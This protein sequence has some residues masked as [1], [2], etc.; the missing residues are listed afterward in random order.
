[1]TN[2]KTTLGGAVSAFGTSLA[3][4]GVLGQF[5]EPPSEARKILWYVALAGFILSGAGKFF[6]GLWAEDRV[7]PDRA[8]S[9]QGTPPVK[10]P[11]NLMLWLIVGF[12]AGALLFTVTGCQT[13]PQ[14]A[15]YTAV[16]GTALTVETALAGYNQFA[17]AG[18]TTIAQNVQVKLAFDRYQAAMRV[19][20]DAGAVYAAT[21]NTSTPAAAALE[22]AALNAAQSITDFLN[23]LQTFGVK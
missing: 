21:G 10:P 8:E 7:K 5:T 22:Q 1:M 4:V 11:T 12:L 20:C 19:V 2:W 17:K 16:S 6:T 9:E 13:T 3:G 23:L 14:R 15:T 18:K